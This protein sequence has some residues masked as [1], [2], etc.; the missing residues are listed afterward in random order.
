MELSA[1]FLYW[2]ELIGIIAFSGTGALMAIEKRL[3]IFGVVILGIITALGGG[4]TRDILL[5]NFPPLMFLNYYYL[6]LALVT[7]LFIFVISY[8]KLVKT[9]TND[10]KI[11]W[12]NSLDAIGLGAFTIAGMNVAF[13]TVYGDN[14]F[15]VIFVGVITGIGGGMIRDVVIGRVPVVLQKQIYAVAAFIG[16]L[17]YN[18]LIAF[19]INNVISM[20][21]GFLVI[22]II[23]LLSIHY[24]LQLPKVEH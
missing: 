10:K 22:V 2:A 14:Q 15:L 13:G 5:G 12:L 23:R 20:I 4:V 11:N 19:S 8:Y 1:E 21:I 16:A 18:F 6:L 17:T 9:K 24:K 3:D 7:A